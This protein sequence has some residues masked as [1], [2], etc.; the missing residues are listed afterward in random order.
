MNI[1]LIM[2]IYIFVRHLRH[3]IISLLSRMIASIDF[4]GMC[5]LKDTVVVNK[6]LLLLD[7]ELLEENMILSTYFSRYR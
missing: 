4:V 2:I 1:V 5:L 3:K 6:Y 7:R